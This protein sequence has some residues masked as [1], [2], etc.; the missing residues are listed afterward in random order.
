MFLLV[1]IKILEL[2]F[3][4]FIFI[5]KYEVGPLIFFSSNLI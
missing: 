2:L 5:Q 4:V 3:L 1:F